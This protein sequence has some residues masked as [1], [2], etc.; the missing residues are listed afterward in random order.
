MKKAYQRPTL[1][2]HGAVERVTLAMMG[3]FNDAGGMGAMTMMAM[4]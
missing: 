4:A 3:S 2:Q 1:R